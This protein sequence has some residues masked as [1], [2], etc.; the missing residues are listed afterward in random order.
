[1]FTFLLKKGKVFLKRIFLFR[2]RALTLR[3]TYLLN[4][5]ALSLLPIGLFIICQY[6]IPSV[7]EL[8]FPLEGMFATLGWRGRVHF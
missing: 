6:S 7:L 8:D 4:E 3:G 5:K 1:M 2:K